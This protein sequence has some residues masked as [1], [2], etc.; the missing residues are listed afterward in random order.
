MN[1]ALQLPAAAS[2]SAAGLFK[3]KT[4]YSVKKMRRIKRMLDYAVVALMTIAVAVAIYAVA[5]I[6]VCDIIAA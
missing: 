5:S 6:I 4:M 2:M 3:G 1:A